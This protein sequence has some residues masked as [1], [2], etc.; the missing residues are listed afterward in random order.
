MTHTHRRSPRVRRPRLFRTTAARWHAWDSSPSAVG[1][2]ARVRW[3]AVPGSRMA[4][5]ASVPIL[6]VAG[7]GRPG[8]NAWPTPATRMLSGG[9]KPTAPFVAQGNLHLCERGARLPP[10]GCG[11][12][13]VTLT[14]LPL[15]APL[16]VVVDWHEDTT[17]WCYL[18]RL[19]ELSDMQW[20]RSSEQAWE[21]CATLKRAEGLGC[22]PALRSARGWQEPPR[23]RRG[24]MCYR[25]HIRGGLIC[26][27]RV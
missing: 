2:P 12:R 6:G 22:C 23:N 16:Y 11:P 1:R 15:T 20:P 21:V 4:L 10:I 18:T 8:R 13:L 27:C 5:W 14:H 26:L 25:L 7:E 24:R 19:Q 9:G 3:H 17:F